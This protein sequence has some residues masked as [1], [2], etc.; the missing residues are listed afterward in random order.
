MNNSL[1]VAD[2]NG[3]LVLIQGVLSF[4]SPC[5]LPLLPLYL[6]Y[7]TGNAKQTLPDGRVE[8]RR[9]KVMLHTLF[10]VLGISVSFFLLGALFSTL[11]TFLN[12][13][14]VWFARLGGILILLMGFV[15]LGLFRLPFLQRERRISWR[16][17]LQKMNPLLAFLL[18]FTFSFAWTPCIGP[19]L[20]SVLIMASN[21]ATRGR[22]NLL[23][24]LYTLGFVV[25]FLLLGLFT[26]QVLNFFDKK[27]NVVR[28]T[29]KISAVLL[30]VIGVM[31]I[32]GWMSSMNNYLNRLGSGSSTG[33]ISV[34]Q[35]QRV[36]E[37]LLPIGEERIK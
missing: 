18:G 9:W 8:Y 14:Q 4:F 37:I 11:G 25:P 1:V 34:T 6:G 35:M 24:L 10:F 31:M 3:F 7:L 23:V 5:V 28:Y 26:T 13:Y 22:G 29:T 20:S 15:Q 32:T 21:A 12:K 27:K 33:S 19:T 17:S 2:V 36:R 30:I 16:W